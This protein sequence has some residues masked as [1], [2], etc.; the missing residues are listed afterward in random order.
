MNLLPTSEQAEITSVIRD[1][2]ANEVSVRRY[3]EESNL[4]ATYPSGLWSQLVE[5]GWFGVSSPDRLGGSGLG[6][7]EEILLA[8]EAGRQLVSPT[9]LATS[10]AATITAASPQEELAK[11]LI[12]G[13]SRVAFATGTD[14]SSLLID[15]MEAD[16]VLLGNDGGLCLFALTGEDELVRS[17][18]E[19]VSVQRLSVDSE[20]VFETSH[21]TDLLRI[22]VVLSA[23]LAGIAEAARD[24]AV[25]YAGEREQFGLPIGSFQ[26]INHLCA[27]MAV[28]SEAAW[29]QVVFSALN[30]GEGGAAS[31]EY[32]AAATGIAKKAAMD[33]ARHNV[34]VHG[35]VGFTVEYDA[36]LLVKRTHVLSQLLD[37][38]LSASE[39]LVAE[40]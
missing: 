17:T 31:R 28:S 24:A 21:E 38:L 2:L 35:G 27:D 36:H 12:E 7:A 10:L 39:V 1:F 29:C 4:G 23:Y 8:R 3:Q 32:V 40:G 37:S 11:E 5:L 34:Q 22:A 15:G 33:N 20:P 16:Y 19:S 30:L 14:Q 6:V 25:A 26:A 13:T 18:D 9:V